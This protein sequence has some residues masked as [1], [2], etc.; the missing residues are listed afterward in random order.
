[1]KK[2]VFTLL[3]LFSF[4]PLFSKTLLLDNVGLLTEDEKEQVIATMDEVS[5]DSGI[6]LGILITNGTE[7]KREADFADDFY[8]RYIDEDDGVLLV[9]DYEGRSVYISTCG[10]GMYVV[11]DS[12]EEVVFD[13]IMNNLSKGEWKDAFVRFALS[14]SELSRDYSYTQY[15]DTTYDLNTGSFVENKGKTFDWA[16][17]VFSFL[18]T[19]IPGGFITIGVMKRKMKSEGLVGNVD[20]Y[21]VPSSFVLDHRRDIYLYSTISKVPR[22]QNNN[23]SSGPGGRSSIGHISS[24]GRIHGGGGRKF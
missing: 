15:S 20:D 24:S 5:K 16:L 1:M 2:I 4:F 23:R 9:L 22:A 8:D 17:V 13:S 3:V 21:V 14:V 19:A 7:G 11:D 18:I 10:Y 6:S 12:G